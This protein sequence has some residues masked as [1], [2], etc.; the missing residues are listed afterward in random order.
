MSMGEREMP[1][2]KWT[3]VFPVPFLDAIAPSM[4]SQTDL[5][6]RIGADAQRSVRGLWNCYCMELRVR[7]G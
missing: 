1:A 7:N 5:G 6:R 4:I 3:R 2:E